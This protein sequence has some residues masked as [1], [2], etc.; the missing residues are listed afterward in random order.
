MYKAI[1]ERVQYSR[2]HA[3]PSLLK[4]LKSES[5]CDYYKMADF[6][7]ISKD[8]LTFRNVLYVMGR[9]LA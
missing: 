9:T 4:Y 6:D 2:G 5:S 7:F 1:F 8:G 3:K